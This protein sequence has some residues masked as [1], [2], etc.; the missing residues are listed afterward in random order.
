MK[1]SPT[2]FAPVAMA[3]TIIEVQRWASFKERALFLYQ[4]PDSGQ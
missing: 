3:N 4:P 2:C 1:K